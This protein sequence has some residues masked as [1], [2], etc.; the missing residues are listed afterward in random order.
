MN[1]KN[2][3]KH[4]ISVAAYL[5]MSTE[6]QQYS[7]DNQMQFIQKYA[8]AHNM[9]IIKVYDD[10]GK[11]G[12]SANGRDNFKRLIQD[13]VTG[14]LKVE[15]LLVYDV[16]RF[17]RFQDNDEAG[18]YSYLLKFH[19]VRIIYCAENLPEH[20]PEIQMLT[21]P[22]LRYAAGAYSRNLSIKV[23][24]GHVNLVQRGFYQGGV[25]G[26][27]LRRKL[28]DSDRKEKF[29][30]QTG[31][32]KS[33]Q[34]DRV[35]LVH[36]PDEE[37][38]TINRIFNLFVFDS[39][40]E[41]LIAETLNREKN[42]SS[43]NIFW[44]RSKVHAVLTNQRLTGN[45]V[46]NK[47]SAK[48]KSKRIINPENEWI[49]Y[50]GFLEPIIPNDK[51]QVVQQIIRDRSAHLSDNEVLDYLRGKLQ[52]H[53]KLS[54][55]II[56]EDPNGPSSSVISH[57]FGGLINAYQL[58]GYTPEKDYSYLIINQRLREIHSAEIK[59]LY[60]CL[61]LKNIHATVSGLLTVY[62]NLK[63]SIVPSRCKIMKSGRLRWV[64][65]LE[66]SLEPDIS[67]VLRMDQ[68]NT[69]VVDFYILPHL[70]KI[71]SLLDLKENNS[72]LLELF[73]F[74][75][76]HILTDLLSPYHMRTA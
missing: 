50:E 47:S 17:G 21:L 52:Q 32:R 4:D 60:D 43:E 74:D 13:V 58:I 69:A 38:K 39:F 72:F 57:R 59:R 54:G 53:G 23:F 65:R 36:G 46:Y 34:T 44:N 5:R 19:G 9:S 22:A 11:S 42:L 2:E 73:R 75:D 7:I 70:E 68:S 24:A 37:I 14:K 67:V 29:I 28:V 76:L 31:E 49:K 15:A 41:Y 55:F 16:S 48:L 63:I 20:S 71:E 12:V 62:N 40:N 30:L 1:I 26:Y 33:L 8:D 10:E 27:G 18:Y 61:E 56:D 51:F 6:H 35:V 25:P 66:R 45:Y 3:D 64:V